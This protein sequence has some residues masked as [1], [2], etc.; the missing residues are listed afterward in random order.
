MPVAWD[1]YFLLLAPAMATLAA[2]LS[3]GGGWSSRPAASVALALAFLAVALPTPQAVLDRAAE[4]GL[5]GSLMISHY[6]FGA[7]L[8]VGFAM[9][10][11]GPSQT[12]P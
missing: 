1:H 2:G 3:R 6:F 4:W 8:I 12:R 10:A 7:V 11:P 9:A 5:P